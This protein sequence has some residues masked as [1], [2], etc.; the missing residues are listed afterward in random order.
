MSI[1]EN[2]G[3]GI[4]NKKTDK[5]D[6]VEIS[7][8]ELVEKWNAIGE[9]IKNRRPDCPLGDG[10]KGEFVEFKGWRGAALYR[11]PNSHEFVVWK[12]LME[13]RKGN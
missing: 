12:D 7:D 4:T 8:E 13:I 5:I 11:C 2:T 9:R 3:K 6:D 1:P 10:E